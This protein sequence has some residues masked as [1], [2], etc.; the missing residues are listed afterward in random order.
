IHRLYT[1]PGTEKRL[2][3]VI[4]IEVSALANAFSLVVGIMHN[5]EFAIDS[6]GFMATV[7]TCRLVHYIVNAVANGMLTLAI[8]FT[9]I[10]RAKLP[11]IASLGS[12]VI[13]PM[14]LIVHVSLAY[15]ASTIG[16]P[17][18]FTPVII[19]FAGIAPTS[20][21]LL[22]TIHERARGGQPEGKSI[23]L[24]LMPISTRTTENEP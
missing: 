7:A 17:V 22:K 2:V 3:I 19:L 15:N 5:V 21:M 4:P 11:K 14:V 10:W 12:G 20:V 8:A 13:Y 6:P 24:P 23:S 16:T 18:N 9:R 1:I